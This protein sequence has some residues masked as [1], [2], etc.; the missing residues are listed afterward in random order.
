MTLFREDMRR[1]IFNVEEQSLV[2]ALKHQHRKAQLN[3]VIETSTLE[4]S[5]LESSVIHG[6]IKILCQNTQWTL[7]SV[8]SY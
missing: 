6:Q 7:T 8:L 4:L 2:P 3:F 5:R 1:K